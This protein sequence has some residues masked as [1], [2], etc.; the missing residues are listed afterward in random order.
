MGYTRYVTLT[1]GVRLTPNPKV[2]L[3]G[4]LD[5]AI[6]RVFGPKIHRAITAC[7]MRKELEEGNRVTECVSMILIGSSNKRA[8]INLSLSLKG[9]AQIRNK[10]YT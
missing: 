6:I 3:K 2:T 7:H 1:G 5:K 10:L 8:I 9:G 4:V